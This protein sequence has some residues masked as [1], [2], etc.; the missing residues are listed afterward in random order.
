VVKITRWSLSRLEWPKTG[1]VPPETGTLTVPFHGVDVRFPI[2]LSKTADG[3][4]VELR[5]LSG[6]Q[7]ET[8]ALFYRS[9]LSGRMAS[10]SDMITSLDTPL[11]LVPMEQTEAEASPQMSGSLPR[12]LRTV[13]NVG[14]WLILAALV[15]A[16][17]GHN[18]FTSL[19][20]IDI[21]HGRVIASI[22]D[23]TD[24]PRG[25]VA[26][27][28]VTPGQRVSSGDILIAMRD[29]DL[30]EKL[31]ANDIE[32]AQVQHALTTLTAD[33]AGL[34]AVQDDGVRMVRASRLYTKHI[35]GGGFDDLRATWIAIRQRDRRLADQVNPAALVA[36]L[37]EDEIK[38]R[39]ATLETL[40]A[41]RNATM[42]WVQANHVRAPQDGVVLGIQARPGAAFSKDMIQF[43]ANAPR[44]TMGW[45]SERFAETV[46]IGM[47]A[48]IGRN[49]NGDRITLD[50]VITDVQAGHHPE[51]PGDFGIIVTV[52]PLAGAGPSRDLLRLGAPVNLEA[53]RQLGARLQKWWSQLWVRDA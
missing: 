16:V 6:R 3:Q 43:E 37:L 7:R 22:I 45:V 13:L 8:L 44:Q 51:R 11:D 10:S 33:L 23:V 5:G 19:N 31:V 9:L 20:R 4:H 49:E 32:R 46:H 1:G 30:E 21:Q 2:R 39:S 15:V 25:Q 35:G 50:A 38:A 29:P 27:G 41:A 52:A 47:P 18:I 14:T 34:M 40:I 36:S 48:S 26:R 17:L 42:Q 12:T 28:L 24:A 53:Q